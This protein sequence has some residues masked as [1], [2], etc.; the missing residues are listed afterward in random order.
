MARDTITIR[1][2][3]RGGRLRLGSRTS[4]FVDLSLA[5]PWFE[6]PSYGTR[7]RT[8]TG[9]SRRGLDFQLTGE[10]PVLSATAGR[11][12]AFDTRKDCYT[13]T[14]GVGAGLGCHVVVTS[15]D[16]KLTYANLKRGSARSGAV[17]VGDR[18]GYA[19]NT[20]HCLDG[21]RRYF[22]HFEVSQG[23]TPREADAFEE[24]LDV[25]LQ[26]DGRSVARPTRVPEGALVLESFDA[27]EWLI[28]SREHRLGPC[29]L[30]VVLKQGSRIR[31]T[32]K[33]KVEI[34]R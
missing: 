6:A 26:V 31:G 19:G 25:V 9:Q 12:V 11:A 33:Q 8:I 14:D 30:E 22:V 4:V 7:I 10:R 29:E 23:S 32:A 13:R 24:P 3:A 27:G 20:G 2:P 34:V 17:K 5:H 21:D 15:G 28:D 18:L 1:R 16:L